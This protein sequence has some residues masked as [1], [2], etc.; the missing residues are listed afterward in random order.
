MHAYRNSFDKDDNLYLTGSFSDSTDFDPGPGITKLYSYPAGVFIS[1]LNKN[2]QFLW[3]KNFDTGWL[4]SASSIAIDQNKNI[5][6]AGFFGET[7][8]FDPGISVS[9]VTSI[10]TSDRFISSYDSIG[11]FRWVKTFSTNE[12]IV[13]RVQS[14]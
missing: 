7:T 5:T 11:N 2:G 8:D 6:V 9:S 3:A 12:D 4:G 14:K 13:F 1:C 10:T